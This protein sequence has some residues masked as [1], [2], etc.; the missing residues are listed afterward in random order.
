MI[1]LRFPLRNE[2][3]VS[4]Q[5]FACV[6]FV[7]MGAVGMALACSA[8]P[9]FAFGAEI[10]MAIFCCAALAVYVFRFDVGLVLHRPFLCSLNPQI[11]VVGKRGLVG[12]ALSAI[13]TAT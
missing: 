7:A 1:Q 5:N 13:Q 12:S 8:E 10:E 4:S 11:I 9:E 6:I 2:L 3:R